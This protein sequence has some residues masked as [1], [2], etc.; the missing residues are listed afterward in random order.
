MRR[1]LMR[2]LPLVLLSA[3]LGIASLAGC[4]TTYDAALVPDTTP[5]TTT[6]LPTGTTDELLEQLRSQSLSLSAIVIDGGDSSEAYDALSDLWAAARPDVV[7]ERPDLI[8]GFDRALAMCQ[9]AVQ[10]QRGA[11]ADKAAR[12]I[13]VLVS[14]WSA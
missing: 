2:Q 13:D 10:Y 4:A 3:A 12:N 1:L 7:A 9:Q 6:T 8:D 11:D 5:A 14:A